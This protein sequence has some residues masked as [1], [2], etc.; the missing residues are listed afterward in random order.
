[1][2]PPPRPSMDRF[3]IRVAVFSPEE[4]HNLEAVPKHTFVIARSQE[5]PLQDLPLR[6]LRDVAIRRYKD[7]YPQESLFQI[8]QSTDA[9]GADLYLNDRVGDIF[10]DNEVLRVIKGSSIRDSLPPD[11]V[12]GR[13]GTV[14]PSYPLQRKRSPATSNLG[15]NSRAGKRQKVY[16]PD[17]PLPS[18]ER[19]PS[20]SEAEIVPPE[21]IPIDEVIPDS[22]VNEIEDGGRHIKQEK[23]SQTSRPSYNQ[24]SPVLGGDD[25]EVVI[26]DSQGK[27]T[28]GRNTT[29]QTRQ[30]LRNTT[31]AREDLQIAA[32]T[33]P[34]PNNGAAHRPSNKGRERSDDISD[35]EEHTSITPAITPSRGISDTYSGFETDIEQPSS[36]LRQRGGV[37]PLGKSK[38]ASPISTKP[39]LVQYRGAATRSKA[40]SSS[41]NSTPKAIATSAP[42][43]T[44]RSASMANGGPILPG[45]TPQDDS[46]SADNGDDK[47][48]GGVDAKAEETA[49]E[50]SRLTSESA[51]KKRAAELEQESHRTV[52]SEKRPEAAMDQARIEREAAKKKSAAI[53][54]AT[55]KIKTAAKRRKADAARKRLAEEERLKENAEKEAEREAEREARAAEAK[56]KRDHLLTEEAR[57]QTEAT[58]KAEAEEREQAKRREAEVTVKA[59][60]VKREE[61]A[62]SEKEARDIKDTEV[63]ST[64][65]RSTSA[66]SPGGMLGRAVANFNSKTASTSPG[67]NVVD[68]PPPP[69]AARGRQSTSPALTRKRSEDIKPAPILPRH[70]SSDIR[71]APSVEPGSAAR[72]V[73]CAEPSP[74]VAGKTSSRATQSPAPIQTPK[75]VNGIQSSGGSFRQTKLVPTGTGAKSVTPK[76]PTPSSSQAPTSGQ[77]VKSTPTPTPKTRADITAALLNTI[78]K[79][80]SSAVKEVAASKPNAI[81]ISSDEESSDD[82]S[83]GELELP[84]LPPPSSHSVA[85]SQLVASGDNANDT[86]SNTSRS[87]SVST[88]RSQRESRSPVRFVNSSFHSNAAFSSTQSFDGSRRGQQGHSN[89]SETSDKSTSGDSA[90]EDEASGS[91]LSSTKSKPIIPQSAASKR[92]LPP[93]SRLSRLR[94]GSATP[95]PQN[96]GARKFSTGSDAETSVQKLLDSQLT[97]ESAASSAPA[98]AQ[99]SPELSG[100]NSSTPVPRPKLTNGN[101][102]D[103]GTPRTSKRP[104]GMASMPSLKLRA[105]AALEESQKRAE[106]ARQQGEAKAKALKDAEVPEFAGAESTEE[107]EAESSSNDNSD[108]D[109][110]DESNLEAGSP[111]DVEMGGMGTP[112]AQKPKAKVNF[113]GLSKKFSKGLAGRR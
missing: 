92:I 93:S 10:A 89:G 13:A 107:S 57:R 16:R 61:A 50:V 17:D 59:E 94:D 7:I 111:D 112:K 5:F 56:L 98:R 9:Y 62:N 108:S 24:P 8:A 19:D 91:E 2:D 20:D 86:A 1:M 30:S 45:M 37:T 48:D 26:S 68:K 31:E 85:P 69:A 35:F 22:Q 6:E 88:N 78:N 53:A 80:S 102:S 83:V 105:E 15:D 38:K 46:A 103:R 25:E 74:S 97:E 110:G 73:S 18:R 36:F 58:E 44:P 32:K 34:K 51:G 67:A 87:A 77:Q 71:P 29:R 27:E 84:P 49:Q 41:N 113:L 47:S 95:T 42:P 82:E 104:A 14:Q 63:A 60:A 76:V 90:S 109:D 23:P 11:Y 40:R 101:A 21:D 106:K 64:R 28:S 65:K 4:A 54:I 72:R 79:G 70:G 81:A 66:I 96:V 12:N 99:A 75:S 100:R 43:I 52:Q 39:K 55:A 3:R 33:T